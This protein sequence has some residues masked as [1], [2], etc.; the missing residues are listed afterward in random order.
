MAKE[1]ESKILNTCDF[2][3]LKTLTFSLLINGSDNVKWLHLLPL[4]RTSTCNSHNPTHTNTHNHTHT[5]TPLPV[6]WGR[7]SENRPPVMWSLKRFEASFRLF[8][9]CSRLKRPPPLPP[10]PPPPPPTPP[11]V[12][13][14]RADWD[15]LSM[16]RTSEQ[17]WCWGNIGQD[18]RA[19]IKT[20]IC[21]VMLFGAYL[22]YFIM[23]EFTLMLN[24]W[25]LYLL[26]CWTI[27]SS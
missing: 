10:P 20:Q 24:T 6:E 3:L 11:E 13:L 22:T 1:S 18:F 14:L 7:L 17:V 2:Q 23:T 25:I 9:L 19:L 15:V 16:S 21:L 12:F 8:F 5:H 27:K 4:T 26:Y